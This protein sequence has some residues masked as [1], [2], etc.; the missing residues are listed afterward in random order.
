MV[1]KIPSH[2]VRARGPNTKEADQTQCPWQELVPLEYWHFGKVFSNEEAQR[3]PGKHPWNH[4]I[5]LVEDAPPMLN[6]KTYLLGEGQQK[7]IDE[8]IADHLKKGYIH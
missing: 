2:F 7:L 1:Q 4:A 6:C 3:F 5:D 8:F